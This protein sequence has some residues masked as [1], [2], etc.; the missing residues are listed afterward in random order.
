MEHEVACLDITP[1]KEGQSHAE[2]CAVGLWTDISARVLRLPNFESLHT[3]M[4]GGGEIGRDSGGG[5]VGDSGDGVHGVCGR[6]DDMV[7]MV[8]AYYCLWPQLSVFPHRWSCDQ[9]Y[10][11]VYTQVVHCSCRPSIKLTK[12]SGGVIE[13]EEPFQCTSYLRLQRSSLGQSWWRVLRAST[14]YCVHWEMVH[15]STSTSTWLQV[16][17]HHMMCY[18]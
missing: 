1:L 16:S 3:E 2:L 18:L 10:V 17:S 6:S 11:E 9:N 5:G 14:T 15:S 7:V 13:R 8:P 12:D 4:L